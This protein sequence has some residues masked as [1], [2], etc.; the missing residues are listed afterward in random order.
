M[1]ENTLE[2]VINT[3]NMIYKTISM[4]THSTYGTI[5][6][7]TRD[8]WITQHAVIIIGCHIDHSTRDHL[9]PS[10]GTLNTWLFNTGRHAETLTHD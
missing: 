9:T 5:K 10:C 1:Q 7:S 8:T 2:E 3:L 6:H 4:W